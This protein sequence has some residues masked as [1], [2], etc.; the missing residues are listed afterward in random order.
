MA[1][2]PL[3]GALAKEPVL[4]IDPCIIAAAE[5]HKVNAITLKAM[6]Y[7]ESR[8]KNGIST[9]NSNSTKDYGVAGI[10]SVHLS[11]LA[12]F[13]ITKESLQYNACLSTYVGAWKYSKKIHK[14]GNSWTAVGD[15]HSE[16]PQYRDAYIWRVQQH[17]VRWGYLEK[18]QAMAKPSQPNDAKLPTVVAG[19]TKEQ[20]LWRQ[21]IVAGARE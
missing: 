2:T 3:C 4:A 10:N 5:Y 13:G 12:K 9:A 6:I 18:S 8:G 7:Q 11:E 19:H 20:P 21:T 1:L 17:L 15:Y 14:H 16:T